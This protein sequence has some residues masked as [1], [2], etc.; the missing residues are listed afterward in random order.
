LAIEYKHKEYFQRRLED[1][2]LY[3]FASVSDAQTMCAFH[4]T[5]LTDQNPKITY[6]LED[7]GQT[8]VV[9]LEFDDHE[10]QMA[11]RTA[12]SNLSD[13]SIAWRS[14]DIEYN[15]IEWLHQDGS[16]SSTSTF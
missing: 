5:Y 4:N 2:S 14:E 12:V 6:A 3:T 16:V 8:L 13:S 9:T 15:K 10:K 1:N 7:S 11:W